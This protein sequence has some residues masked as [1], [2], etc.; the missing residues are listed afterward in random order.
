MIGS[1]LRVTLVSTDTIKK[2]IEGGFAN[3]YPT[4]RQTIPAHSRKTG[5]SAWHQLGAVHLE[6]D[7]YREGM[8]SAFFPDLDLALLLRYLRHSDQCDA[9]NEF[10]QYTRHDQQQ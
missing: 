7:E 5:N 3:E 6:A 1:L 8:R 9:V 4:F 2:Y 10:L